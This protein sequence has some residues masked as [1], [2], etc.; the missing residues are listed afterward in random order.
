MHLKDALC[1]LGE[2][3]LFS[4]ENKVSRMLLEAK[5]VAVT[6]IFLKGAVCEVWPEF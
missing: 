6:S 1:S 2:E 4:L 5:K 3:I